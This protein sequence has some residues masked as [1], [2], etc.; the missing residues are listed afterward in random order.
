MN[1]MNTMSFTHLPA[2]TNFVF[3][4][5][6]RVFAL[7]ELIQDQVR[8]EMTVRAAIAELKRMDARCLRDI[9]ICR[10]EI[11]QAVRGRNA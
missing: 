8:H 6:K 1:T 11:E 4:A 3:A 2:S 10:N 5:A 7:V 9:G